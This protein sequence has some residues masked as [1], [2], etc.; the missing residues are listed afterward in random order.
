MRK[1]SIV[2]LV[3]AILLMAMPAFAQDTSQWS[4]YLFDSINNALIRFSTSAETQS[5]SLGI[6]TGSYIYGMSISSDGSQVAYCYDHRIDPN[7]EGTKKLVVR[8]IDQ[9]SNLIEMELGQVV[10]CSVTAFNSDVLAL[11]LVFTY[12]F[13]NMV[14]KL[15]E[16]R[17]IDPLTGET[18]AALTNESPE[19]PAVAMFG[20]ETVPLLAKVWEVSRER[21]RFLAIP[22]VGSEGPAQLPAFEWNVSEG[23]VS[24]LPAAFGRFNADYLPETGEVVFPALDESLGAAMPNGPIPQANQVKILDAEGERTIYQNTDWVITG[25]SFV[26]NGEAV[27]VSMIAGYDEQNPEPMNLSR[28][29]LVKRDGTIIEFADEYNGAV[30]VDAIPNGAILVYTPQLGT[31][32]LD[33]SQIFLV[34]SDGTLSHFTDVVVDYSLGWS[35]PQLVWTSPSAISSDLIPFAGQ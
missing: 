5:F 29:V 4:A 2:I 24:E 16:L 25:A 31:G 27:L 13:N 21:V 32:G 28:Y 12:D 26:S 15:W 34:A 35:P 3:M 1:S 7:A 8:D 22:Y 11:S 19:M 17:L 10:G 23:T 20:Q 6:P 30:F 14:G 33:A 9:E 18:R